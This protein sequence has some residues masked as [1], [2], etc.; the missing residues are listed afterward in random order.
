VIKTICGILLA[1]NPFG[2]CLI[3]AHAQLGN[4][5][6]LLSHGSARSVKTYNR[7]L[8]FVNNIQSILKQKKSSKKKKV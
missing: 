4:L 7:E 1:D 6:K 2:G 5:H 3:S 8:K